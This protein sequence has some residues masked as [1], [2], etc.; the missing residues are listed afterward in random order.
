MKPTAILEGYNNLGIQQAVRGHFPAAEVSFLRALNALDERGVRANYANALRRMWRF[1]E[2][3]QQIRKANP[4]QDF[5]HYVKGSIAYET[6]HAL[7]AIKHLSR[8]KNATADNNYLLAMAH[9]QAGLWK[10][11]FRL[12]EARH[13]RNKLP[14]SGLP[15]WEGQAGQ[16][17][18]HHEQGFGDS[19]MMSRFLQSGQILSVPSPLLRLFQASGF[20]AQSMSLPMPK[21]DYIAPLMS[22]PYILG[23]DHIEPPGQYL[24][25]PEAFYLPAPAGTKLKIGLV[26][27]AKA[28]D[29][30]KGR[31]EALHG[32]QK[33]IPL[34]L[35]LPLASTPGVACYGLQT[36]EAAKDIS[37][38]GAE[39]LIMNLGQGI[40]D[41]ADLAS[42]MASMDLIV[43]VDTAPLHLAGAL[44]KPAIGLLCYP[45]SWQ[46]M[47]G[48]KTPWYSSITL[49]RQP[50][51]FD[52]KS[53]V[54]R[55]YTMI[56]QM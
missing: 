3:S 51:P 33:S 45:G 2:A 34:E 17:L 12:H 41:F 53:A 23:I 50:K 31:E 36:G 4:R 32:E 35:L 27:T 7:D 1:K 30:A 40:M 8:I 14:N 56:E 48:D 9:L 49:V 15:Q 55:V 29:Q 13:E 38:L 24:R 43:S 16:V 46:W 47:E 19:L 52:W 22:L 25:A 44:N 10:E 18:V 26:W 11:G 6:G 37:K 21:A 5:T 39:A 54:D 42:F 28:Q 20:N